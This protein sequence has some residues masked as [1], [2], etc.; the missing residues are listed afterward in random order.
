MIPGLNGLRKLRFGF[1]GRGRRGGGRA[2]YFLL[3]ADEVAVMVFAY[4]KS[5]QEDLTEEQKAAALALIQEMTDGTDG[6]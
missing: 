1:G 2:V 3:L 5:G 6:T 4:G